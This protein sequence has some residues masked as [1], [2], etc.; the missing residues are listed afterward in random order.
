MTTF[1]SNLI[2]E[3]SILEYRGH[4]LQ[5][6][7]RQLNEQG[8][9]EEFIRL[10]AVQ[11]KLSNDNTFRDSLGRSIRRATDGI[12]SLRRSRSERY[13]SVREAAMPRGLPV[14]APLE[15]ISELETLLNKFDLKDLYNAKN[16]IEQY[17]INKEKK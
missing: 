6:S 3:L 10:D 14:Y 11:L 2:Q 9:L 12:F 7:I 5:E 8:C 17:I 4:R 15:R 1:F 13:F 16:L